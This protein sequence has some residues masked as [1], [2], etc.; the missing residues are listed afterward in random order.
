[1]R[2][3][4]AVDPGEPFRASLSTGHDERRRLLPVG[5]TDPALMHVTLLFLG[6]W[7]EED[8]PALREALLDAA[9]GPQV[10]TAAPGALGGFPDL[11]RPRVLFLHLASGGR[12]EA[13]AT[14]V[15]AAVAARFPRT[16][17]DAKPFRAH[18]TL[19]RIRRPLA[20]DE[21]AALASLPTPDA[22]PFAVRDFRLVR[23]VLTPRG[24]RYTDLAVFPLAPSR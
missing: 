12:L 9:A 10:F 15:R 6:E 1:M 2:L 4:V 22:A 8:L 14:E 24:P 7:P 19:A 5:W 11:R 17:L 20:P 13:L 16:P 23:S 18:L 21:T 3:F